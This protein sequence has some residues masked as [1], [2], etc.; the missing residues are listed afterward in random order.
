MKALIALTICALFSSMAFAI[1]LSKNIQLHGFATQ[2]YIKTDN[3]NFFG[4]TSRTKGDID[5][6]ELGINASYR[7]FSNFHIA[8]QLIS[9]E[10]GA[11]D[12]STI[13]VD[14]ALAD[15]QI[16]SRN[17]YNFGL[18]VGRVKN[19]LGFY[20][21]TRDVAFTR[22]S[23]FLPQSIY[24]DRVRKLALSADGL[25]IYGQ[26]R[27]KFGDFDFQFGIGYP[28]VD[29]ET[30]IA[31]FKTDRDGL[32]KS[33]LSLIAHTSY[34]L[35]ADN[36]KI[37][38]SW[39]RLSADY[40]STGAENAAASNL[41]NANFSFT[42]I[43]LSA[44]STHGDFTISSEYA[45]RFFQFN[46]MAPYV[47]EDIADLTGESYYIQM[48]YR[49]TPLFEIFLRYDI[50]YLDR[51]DKDGLKYEAKGYGNRIEQFAKDATAGIALHINRTWLLRAEYHHIEGTAWLPVQDNPG[52]SSNQK[53]WQLFSVLVSYKF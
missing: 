26:K 32:M 53:N 9:R 10:A 23:I 33:N 8:A 37:A 52:M 29:N 45:L 3:Y 24:F 38:L 40:M 41:R 27:H 44:L 13:Q 46:N 39:V 20:N 21:E 51:N 22:N 11:V 16:T 15:L 4:E 43:I 28:R 14:Y 18:R 6:R 12:N 48:Q 50:I 34:S 17:Q 30:E 1:N 42:P 47:P 35:N 36:Q 2:G 31:I 7:A 19:P 49:L 25:H 5:F